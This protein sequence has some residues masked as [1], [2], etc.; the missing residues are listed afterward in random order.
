M[1]LH[2]HQSR[3]KRLENAVTAVC[4]W[5]A[6]SGVFVAM[7]VL[8]P[9]GPSLTEFVGRFWFP[10]LGSIAGLVGLVAYVRGGQR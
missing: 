5:L 4:L 8:A 1:P 2:P 3:R 6:I 7:A 9:E 10:L